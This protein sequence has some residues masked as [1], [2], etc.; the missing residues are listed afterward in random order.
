MVRGI[1]AVCLLLSTMG[2][3]VT[4]AA[5]Y[6]V[7]TQ[8][9]SKLAD[10][11]F[12]SHAS[13]QDDSFQDQTKMN[14]NTADNIAKIQ[15]IFNVLAQVDLE[16]AK[17]KDSDND[18]SQLWKGVS[19][20]IWKAGKD[21]L[22]N[23]LCRKEQAIMAL[24]QELTGEVRGNSKSADDESYGN[25][26]KVRAQLQTLF[27]AL[28]MVEANMMQSENNAKAEVSER[29]KKKIEVTAQGLLC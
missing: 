21:F 10:V 26:E 1:I 13:M 7:N 20:F 2:P 17:V 28:R 6:N 29:I 16:S 15:G 27:N 8:E 4:L 19:K 5:A 11:L 9:S 3:T 24:L 25:E 12:N 18:N 22:K 23:V 14:F